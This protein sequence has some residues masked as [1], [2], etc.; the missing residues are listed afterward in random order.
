MLGSIAGDIIGSVYEWDRIKTT[1]FPL[2]QKRCQYT[3][4][5]V[6]TVATAYSILNQVPYA[7]SYKDFSRRYPERGYG[8]NFHRWIFSDT[9][10]PYNSW[11]N[12]SAMRVSPVGFAFE[13]IEKVLEQ[14]KQ[15]A[16]VTHNHPEGVKGAQAT[17]LSIFLARKGND[18]EAIRKAIT[19]RFNY[20]LDRTVAEIRPNYSFD[21][22]CMGTVPE[23]IIAFLDS[24][25][26]EHS[27]R[28]AVS[29]GGDSDTLACITGGIAEAYYK[30]VPEHIADETMKIIHD[31]FINII[32]L[33]SKEY[34]NI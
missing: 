29:L 24:D 14:A 25:D 12:G 18:K 17:A 22:S 30:G 20:D 16:E 26:Y 34:L 28:L 7:Q 3:D 19:E 8:G 32:K 11:G 21:V 9:L 5:S 6:L 10:E 31:E 1:E 27:V 15:S 4:D 2:F 13:S 33:F 23:A